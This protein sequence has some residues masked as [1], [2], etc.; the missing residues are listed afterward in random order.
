MGW[1]GRAQAQG[2]PDLFPRVAREARSRRTGGSSSPASMAAGSVCVTGGRSTVRSANDGCW[3]E[4]LTSSS[5]ILVEGKGNLTSFLKKNVGK[6]YFLRSQ[7]ILN[8]TKF[9]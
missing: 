7:I 8:L 2:Q 3:I 5:S 6:S 1:G 9:P 4:D